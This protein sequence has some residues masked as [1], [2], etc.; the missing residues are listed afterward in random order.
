[1]VIEEKTNCE[2]I[3]FKFTTQVTYL[4]ENER[5]PVLPILIY[6]THE[7]LEEHPIYELRGDGNSLGTIT[8]YVKNTT[9]KRVL[10]IDYM[11]NTVD[12]TQDTLSPKKYHNVGRA[13]HE[14]AIYKMFVEKCE[15][16]SLDSQFGT[17]LFHY[18]CGYRFHSETINLASYNFEKSV[19]HYWEG[20]K[21][22]EDLEA[23]II[24]IQSLSL[25]N[26][27]KENAELILEK[28]SLDFEE[29]LTNGMHV[30]KNDIL[31]RACDKNLIQ[32]TCYK[33]IQTLHLGSSMEMG[34]ES[35]KEWKSLMSTQ[36]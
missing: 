29:I 19:T 4:H 3:D 20:K 5:I 24:Q 21:K 7:F 34:Q 14:F 1:M 6:N 33:N 15:T 31:R 22:G 30:D 26:E 36:L 25:F 12:N 27:I 8:L 18:K 2:L 16:I 35:I 23:L 28:T 10:F 11:E 13:L 9:E 32:F 17:N